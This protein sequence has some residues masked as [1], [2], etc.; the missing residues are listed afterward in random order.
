M[1]LKYFSICNSSLSYSR[2]F[3][4]F[5]FKFPEMKKCK[6]ILYILMLVFVVACNQGTEDGIK[7]FRNAVVQTQ[8]VLSLY[9]TDGDSGRHVITF[10]ELDGMAD[11]NEGDC[12]QVEFRADFTGR[13][14]SDA[15]DV[16]MYNLYPI[17]LW[18]LEVTTELP[19]TIPDLLTDQ[20]INPNI[21]MVQLLKKKLF[22]PVEIRERLDQ[23]EESYRLG[24]NPED[25]LEIAAHGRR[26]YT[27]YLQAKRIGGTQDTI[28]TSQIKMHALQ[29]DHFIDEIAAE[30]TDTI[31]FR[32][33]YPNRYSAD[34]TRVM[35]NRSDIYSILLSETD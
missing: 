26:V 10:P 33:S 25:T 1:N 15:Y 20:F 28:T 16:I 23:Q 9:T 13:P 32:L 35:W 18:P 29:L 34:S 30:E 31:H 5:C 12:F 3:N 22:V 21:R 27:I 11:L 14:Q 17:P 24:Y 7:Y 8:P 4:Y 19:D 6:W 2:Y